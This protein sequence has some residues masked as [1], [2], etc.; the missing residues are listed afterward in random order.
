MK[1]PF[2]DGLHLLRAAACRGLPAA[3]A[4]Q[5]GGLGAQRARLA[6][7]FGLGVASDPPNGAA[8]RGFADLNGAGAAG[9]QL[10]DALHGARGLCERALH[11]SAASRLQEV[12][13]SD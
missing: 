2:A 4:V 3:S 13:S 12:S 11:H 8:G 5:R 10:Q 6:E 7:L 1:R 9:A